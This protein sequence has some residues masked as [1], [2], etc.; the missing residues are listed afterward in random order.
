ML[1]KEPR[2]RQKKVFV[3]KSITGVW[4]R[5]KNISADVRETLIKELGTSSDTDINKAWAATCHRIAAV[6][7]SPPPLGTHIL[8][9]IPRKT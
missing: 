3:K 6:K 4:G 7:V 2:I 1:Q 9:R 8:D 5:T